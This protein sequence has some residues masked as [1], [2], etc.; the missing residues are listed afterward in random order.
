MTITPQIQAEIKRLFYAE[1]FT[2]NAIAEALGIHHDTVKADLDT[3]KF[4]S[5]LCRRTSMLDPYLPV[6]EETLRLYPK[7]RCTRIMQLLRDRGY[8]GRISI[9]RQVVKGLR[10]KATVAFMP[11]TMLPGEQAQVDWAHFGKLPVENTERKLSCFVLVLSFSRAMFA[12]FTFDQTMES[13][14]RSHIK[15][16][17]YLGGIS[18]KLLYDNLKTV[19]LGRAGGD[20]D[21]NPNHLE[22]AGHYRFKPEACNVRSGW[23][24]GRVERSIRYIRDNFFAA[25]HFRDIADANRQLESWLN[26]TA[27]KRAW[28]EDRTHTVFDKWAEEKE[29]LLPLPEHEGPTEIMHPVR[30][31]KLPFIRFDLNDYSI[32]HKQV[33]KPLSVIANEGNI[34]ILDGQAELAKHQRSYGKGKKIRTDEHFTG[35]L[36][37]RGKAAGQSKQTAIVALIPEAESLLAGGEALGL[38]RTNE[39]KKLSAL[40]DEYGKEAVKEA[41]GHAT[42]RQKPRAAVV[43]QILY[44]GMA[45]TLESMGVPIDLPN[46]L[47]IKQLTVKPHDLALYDALTGNKENNN[48]QTRNQHD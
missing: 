39:L 31:S 17:Q 34:R 4:N 25:R 8:Q 42:A 15:A 45:R 9:L 18:R 26:E 13:F 5:F 11:L 38:M 30:S 22:F 37:T 47:N 44:E 7:I 23:E 36:E 48:D 6:I 20:I 29:K 35:L 19:V 46:R 43:A 1:H 21:F 12:C 33:G 14:L 16:F 24:K 40:I 3:S 27:N 2:M 28:P 41:I 10:P 32:P